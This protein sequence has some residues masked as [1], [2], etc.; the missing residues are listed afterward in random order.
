M[1]TIYIYL[2]KIARANHECLKSYWSV[3]C[4]SSMVYILLQRTSVYINKT[5]VV[6]Y[7]RTAKALICLCRLGCRLTE[8]LETVD[9]INGY[10]KP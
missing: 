7:M 4:H 1:A 10:Q 6:Q 9:C 2:R 3:D 8:L 5:G